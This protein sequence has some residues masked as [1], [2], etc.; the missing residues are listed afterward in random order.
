[1]RGFRVLLLAC[2]LTASAAS[3]ACSR[4][5]PGGSQS[6]VNVDAIQ[7][8]NLGVAEMNR[9]RPAQALGLFRRAG[10]S[11]PSMFTARLNEGIALLNTQRN[12]EARDVLLDATRRQPQSARAWY[13]LGILYRNLSESDLA[14]DAFD[15]VARIDPD[16]ADTFYFLGQLHAQATHYDQAI[17]AYQRCLELDAQH[18]SAEFGLARAYQLSGNDDA[19]RQHLSRFEELTRSG[20]GK[21][22]SLV[23]GEQGTY[24]TAEPVSGG[25][26][27]PEPFMV[28]FAA[29]SDRGGIRVDG[30]TASTPTTIAPLLGGGACFI[31]YDSDG[32]YDLF[33]PGGARGISLHRNAGGVFTDVTAN[34]GLQHSEGLGCAVGD[35]DNDGRDDIAVGFPDSVNLYRNE[36][37]GSFRDVTAQSGIRV[38]GLPLGVAFVDYDHDG[39]VDLYVSRFENFPLGPGGAF[40]FPLDRQQTGANLLW[41]NNGNGTFTDSTVSAGLA[42]NAVGIAALPTD[43]NN[44]RAIDFLLTGL[45]PSPSVFMNSREGPFRLADVWKSALPSLAAGAVAFDFNKDGWMDIA[46]THWSQ[47]GLSVWKNLNGTG[48]E[49]VN[50]PELQGGRGWGLAAVDVDNDGWLDL[51][52]AGER[53]GGGELLLLRNLGGDRFSD[54]TRA[55]GLDSLPLVRPRAVVAA[56]ID[57][58]GDSDLLVTQNGG[59]PVLLRNEGGNRRRSIRLALQGLS[60]NRSGIGTKVEVFAGALRQKWEVSSSSGYLG[61]GAPEILAGIGDARE[62]D[63][64]RLL[65]PTGV[66]QDEVQLAAGQRHLLKEIDRRGSSCPVV[67]VWDGERYRFISDIIGPGIVGEWIGPGERNVPDPTEYLKIDGHLV[68][69]KNGR[70]SFRF[71]EV[72]EEITYLD[73]VRLLAIDHPSDVVVNPNEYFATT[74]P[75]PDFK[76][77]TSRNA[78]LP[79]AA[80]DDKGRNVLPLLS[81]R[82]GRYVAGFE[83]MQYPGFAKMHYLELDLGNVDA[84]QPLRLLMHG[85]IDYFTVTSIF[86]AYQGGVQAVVPFLEVPDGNG[87]WKRISEDIGFPAGLP[88]TMVSDWTGRLPAGTSRVRIGTNLKIYWDQILIDTTPQTTSV[89]VHEVPLAEAS[90]AFRGYPRKVEGTVPGDVSYIHE[91]VSPSGPFARASGYHTAYGNVLPL[92]SERDDRFVVIG[93]GEEV[94]LE[95]NSSILPALRPGWSRDYFLYADGFAKDMDFYSAYS[96]TVE[97]LPF[98]G[99]GPYTYGMTQ[100]Y[101]S[102]PAHLEYRLQWNSRYASDRSRMSYRLN[103]P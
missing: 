103:F 74:L 37:G 92:V 28:R 76:V 20:K 43:F 96:S 102:D 29:V 33:L 58:D 23:Y 14:I 38:N 25:S 24:S 87:G 7:S 89:D 8:N 77:I 70:L 35:Y 9:G 1:M 61:Q 5:M 11:D 42:G 39:D 22:I 56:D 94:S 3:A 60:D 34:S 52:V 83:S 44:D 90:F 69:P 97:P 15:K 82:D 63:I 45:G 64:V 31:D 36:G 54:V 59:P 62:A 85:F 57:A 17:R 88:R 12:D 41:R 13:N 84:N 95:F 16:D 50:V 6:G 18:L 101:P 78:R 71:A 40:N 19:A 53:G 48:F 65:W 100:S 27:A 80:V 4:R 46:L 67:F 2:L 73:H 51:A 99:M 55:V 72:M 26:L 30:P 75:L 79:R 49:R 93:S 86:A 81:K 21:P 32:R 91:N 68:K 66:P 10:Q 98:H 47:P